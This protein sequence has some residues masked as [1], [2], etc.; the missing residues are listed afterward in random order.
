MDTFFPNLPN[1]VKNK[2]TNEIQLISGR[3]KNIS[4]KRN[5]QEKNGAVQKNYEFLKRVET[6]NKKKRIYNQKKRTHNNKKKRE[7]QIS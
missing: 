4:D 6:H 5:V 7:K 1:R 3:Y 2:Q